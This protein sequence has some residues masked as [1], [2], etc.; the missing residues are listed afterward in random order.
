MN[1]NQIIL[2]IFFIGTPLLLTFS[3]LVGVYLCSKIN[4]LNK[5]INGNNVIW[6][7]FF[8]LYFIDIIRSTNTDFIVSGLRSFGGLAMTF[9]AALIYSLIRNRLKMNTIDVK[10]Y[11]FYFGVAIISII[12]QVLL[13]YR[14]KI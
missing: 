13:I 14:G 8:L 6:F 4:F 10:F 1:D 3:G 12:S 11:Y 7:H 5:N 2:L 9:L